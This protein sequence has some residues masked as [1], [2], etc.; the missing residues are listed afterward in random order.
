MGASREAISRI[1]PLHFV[2]FSVLGIIYVVVVW[3]ALLRWNSRLSVVEA[4]PHTK[5]LPLNFLGTCSR[6]S[7]EVAAGTDTLPMVVFFILGIVYVVMWQ[8]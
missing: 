4:G 2:V 5:S 6:V 3:G 1:G 8:D 7:V